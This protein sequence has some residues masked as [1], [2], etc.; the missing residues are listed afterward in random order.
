M[1]KPT[2]RR[3]QVPPEILS[4]VRRKS[5]LRRVRELLAPHIDP[6]N[7]ADLPM[8]DAEAEAERVREVRAGTR[9]TQAAFALRFRIP[10]GTVRDWEQGRRRP[11]AAA[12][13]YLHVIEREPKAVLQALNI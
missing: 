9:L 4:V 8:A 11:D 12:L 2:K 7:E 6:I 10:V 3:M 13:A 5:S 1:T